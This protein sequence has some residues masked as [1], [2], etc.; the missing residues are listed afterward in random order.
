MKKTLFSLV[1]ILTGC[2]LC[3]YAMS[4]RLNDF[5]VIEADSMA[6]Y[7]FFWLDVQKKAVE[8][9]A[10]K[11]ENGGSCGCT[12][13]RRVKPVSN[14]KLQ[15]RIKRWETYC[16]KADP[17]GFPN[18]FNKWN[19]TDACLAQALTTFRDCYELWT[20][21][22]HAR[23]FDQ[24]ER[25][26]CNGVLP[27]W[28]PKS[29]SKSQTEAT[30]MLRHISRLAYAFDGHDVYLN[31][32]MRG[33]SHIAD[34]DYDIFLKT[35][36]S[37]PWYNETAISVVDNMA[38]MQDENIEQVDNTTFIIHHDLTRCD[39]VPLNIHLRIPSWATGTNLPAQWSVRLPKQRIQ[40]F[41]NGQNTTFE[42]KDGYAVVEGKWSIG[43]NISF[44]LPTPILR[45]TNN[46]KIVLQRGPMVYG[47]SQM[48]PN[49]CLD[50]KSAISHDFDKSA[51]AIVLKLKIPS[52]TEN[53]LPATTSAADGSAND[54][55]RALPFYIIKERNKI[56]I[57]AK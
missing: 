20:L 44:K 17:L 39:S 10:P 32:L 30:Q 50:P 27:Y 4:S 46:S 25:V 53:V 19:D 23:F 49:T 24:A 8:A 13:C 54:F 45:L 18:S 9:P 41:A 56:F 34:T 40:I 48:A 12:I 51:A 57:P 1:F 28:D 11:V 42:N 55:T 29:Q 22:R 7:D 52:Q 35:S 15:T 33:S 3:G 37:S 5:W 2:S 14:S 38:M 43:D 26:L 36:N 21:T 6:L 16:Q 47:I 31:M